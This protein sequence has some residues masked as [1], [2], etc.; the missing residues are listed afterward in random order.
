MAAVA[1]R[2]EQLTARNR[3]GSF[4]VP[5][6]GKYRIYTSDTI[7]SVDLSCV[8]HL[9]PKFSDDAASICNLFATLEVGAVPV[10]HCPGFDFM[11]FA[12]QGGVELQ[13]IKDV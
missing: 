4:V 9:S 8:G 5:D 2:F 1:S 13:R 6:G 11:F 3:D 12:Q 7:T 10:V